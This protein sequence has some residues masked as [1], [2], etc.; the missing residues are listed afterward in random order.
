MS[1]VIAQQI[2]HRADDSDWH[3]PVLLIGGRVAQNR[4]RDSGRVGVE[5]DQPRQIRQRGVIELD[6]CGLIF[7][8]HCRARE[9]R[10]ARV[11]AGVVARIPFVRPITA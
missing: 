8:I 10:K 4:V 11:Y 3:R 1:P 6:T 7:A 9:A 5:R 2:A